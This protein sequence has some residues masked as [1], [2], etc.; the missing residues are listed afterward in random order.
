M[1]HIRIFCFL[2]LATLSACAGDAA[3]IPDAPNRAEA[4]Y[5]VHCATCHDN[6]ATGAPSRAA[7]SAQLP[8]AI[9]ATLEHGVMRE[10]GKA[11]TASERK[12]LA[13]HLGAK[14]QTA[15]SKV[16]AGELKL[17]GEQSW[18]GWGNGIGNARY[19][20]ASRAGIG[21]ENVRQFELKWAF[22]FPEAA[23]ARS[24]PAV[25]K[26]AIFTGS[27]SG[28]VY[29]LDPQTGCV[30][31]TFDAAS[32]VRSAP[33]LGRIGK[34]ITPALF[35]GDFDGNVYAVEAKSGQLLWKTAV[36]DHPAGTIT[37]SP[38]LHEGRLYVPLSSTEVV[39]AMDAK[40]E[41]CTFRGGVVALESQTGR[42]AWRMH[43]V[44]ASRETGRNSGGAVTR[45]PSGAPIWS[46]PTIDPKRGLLYVGTGENYSSPATGM[47]DAIVAIE[48]A[49]GKVRWVQQ[50][51]KG[52]AWNAS[53]GRFGNN[54]NCPREDGPDF[55][56][57]A[58]PILA[59]LANGREIILAGQ[60]SG[61]LYGLD[62][63][64]EGR[65]L[66]Q[67][68]AGM[69]GFNGGVHW[70]MASDGRTLFA[71]IADTPG[72]SRPTGPPRQ[73]MHAFDAATGRPLWSRIEANV[74][75]E[76]K[77]ECRTA[78]SAPVTLTDGVIFAGALNGILRAYSTRDGSLL[79]TTDTRRDFQTVN[80]V[81][82]RG[83]SIDSAGPV[84]ADGRL[85]VNSGYDKFGQIGGNVLLVFGPANEGNRP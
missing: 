14:A 29:A 77:H 52:D 72:H 5:A 50:T 58:P 41:C 39:S 23:R 24:Q 59:T 12:L 25:T 13:G 73:G 56:F 47:S 34:G 60:K 51:V 68:R 79:W 82:G 65:I 53:C 37:G 63:N 32:E 30:W 78:L 81:P 44:E 38:A 18:N 64:A 48:L 70:G 61:V 19:Q 66:W 15:T 9:L 54:V 71:G 21:P 62:P 83:G 45:G 22:A 76:E 17:S 2:L 31:W 27:Q 75:A 10:Q 42:I 43:T 69:G 26:E 16:C 28:R 20:P 57:G 35:F 46:S 84:V 80:G 55:D 49:T 8:A 4:L 1:L 3:P 74:C 33:V 85:I 67:R 36:R 11:L 6:G 40:Y 7:I